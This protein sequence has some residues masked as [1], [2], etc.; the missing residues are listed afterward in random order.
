NSGISITSMGTPLLSGAVLPLCEAFLR[1]WRQRLWAERGSGNAVAVWDLADS[2]DGK[3][4]VTEML[5]DNDVR[6]LICHPCPG[7]LSN[8]LS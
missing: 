4:G 2:A 3:L 5:A 1:R 7:K 8:K 6:Q